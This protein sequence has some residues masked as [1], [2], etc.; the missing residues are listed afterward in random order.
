MM[1]WTFKP[2]PNLETVQQLSKALNIAPSLATLL[3]QRGITNFEEAR[4]FF[5]PHYSHLHDPFL[6]K[7]MRKAVERIEKAIGN[8]ETIMV[9]GD[10]DVDGTTAVALVA[11]YL[12]SKS[13]TI[14]TY[15]PDRHTEGYGLSKTGIEFAS[16]NGVQL[17]VI[18][19]C[20][21]KA[22]EN[23][24][25]A[26]SLGIDCIVC[27]H[28]TPS[29]TLPNAIAILNPKQANCPYPFKELCGC[30]IGFKLIQALSVTEDFETQLKPYLDL[31]VTAIGADIVPMVGEN[32]TL[33]ALGLEIL[34]TSPRPGLEG[35]IQ[36]VQKRPITI[37]DV[38]FVLAPRINAAGRMEHGQK[39]VDLLMENDPMVVQ[40]KALL[41]EENN[42][43][44]RDLDTKITEQALLQIDTE[45][46]KTSYTTVVFDPSWHKGVIGIVASRLI[47]THYR[48]TVVLSQS[49][50]LLT[51]S[52]RS[53]HGYNLYDALDA[54]ADLL[55][56]FGGH[57]YAAGLTLKMQ[58]LNAFKTRFEE[59]V[60]RTMPKELLVPELT[61]DLPLKFNEIT[62][63][64]Y[65]I[66]KQFGPFGPGNMTP[67]FMSEAVK[68]V[69]HSKLVGADQKHLRLVVKQ[70]DSKPI[71]GIG[72]NLANKWDLV[73]QAKEFELCYGL[74]ENE[75]KDK[76]S[77]QLKVKDLRAPS[78]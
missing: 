20:G 2:L 43:K 38:V 28:H 49:G 1:R 44:R 40:S 24:A 32:R 63:K 51:G 25:L 22:I 12:K 29:N 21:I 56:R 34:N 67:V 55:E 70:I 69:G 58:N 52:A 64:F 4:Q 3:V 60:H 16:A 9:Y 33:A 47:E 57:K 41:V 14:L 75:W 39:A 6:M 37:T 50:D 46:T 23:I 8:Q 78:L 11:T 17:M 18:L 74:D 31:V 72:F 48:P 77:L 15:I 35:M 54:C 7:D 26:E 36:S 19:D 13:E 62:P 61:I 10:Y 42:N 66:L 76:L 45:S 27:D 53:V 30:G 5:R 59:V 65:R 71:T 68:D 73:Q